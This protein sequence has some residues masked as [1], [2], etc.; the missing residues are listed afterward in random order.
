MTK[1]HLA[2]D[3]VVQALTSY[4]TGNWLDVAV[5]VQ[6][7]PYIRDYSGKLKTA[8]RLLTE[9]GLGVLVNTTKAPRGEILMDRM[10]GNVEPLL[11]CY[12]KIKVCLM[13]LDGNNWTVPKSRSSSNDKFFATLNA[14][15]ILS[16]RIPDQCKSFSTAVQGNA[17]ELFDADPVEV[18]TVQKPSPFRPSPITQ[19]RGPE[20]PVEGLRQQMIGHKQQVRD[21]S[22]LHRPTAT[23]PPK[24]SLPNPS[25]RRSLAGVIEPPESPRYNL[26]SRGFNHIERLVTEYVPEDNRQKKYA[27]DPATPS[28]IDAEKTMWG[29]SCPILINRNSASGATFLRGAESHSNNSSASA[30]FTEETIE[31]RQT[32]TTASRMYPSDS[33]ILSPTLSPNHSR[34]ASLTTTDKI[35]NYDESNLSKSPIS[36]LDHRDIEALEF[37]CRQVESQV[38]LLRESMKNLTESVEGREEPAIFVSHSKFIILTAHKI[39][40][41]GNEITERLLNNDVRAKIKESS[42]HLTLCIRGV[43]SSTKTAALEYP[44]PSSMMEMISSVLAL[45]DAVRIIHSECRKAL[46]S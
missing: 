3:T 7:I 19:Q 39:V 25:Q 9:F 45:G 14:I 5:L 11:E 36:P 41:S 44:E 15:M 8:L 16:Q 28:H 33:N 34:S 35:F 30:I 10:I 43:V 17:K 22:T 13:H 12:Y 21:S 6:T 2:V 37:F 23:I 42:S 31:I 38:M 32:T 20:M 46:D 27:S 26:T 4:C 1:L 29:G 40:H 18:V 24:P